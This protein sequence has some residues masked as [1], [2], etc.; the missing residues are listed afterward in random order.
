MTYSGTW[1]MP[2]APENRVPGTLSWDGGDHPVLE[3][4]GQVSPLR[5]PAPPDGDRIEEYACILGRSF[6]G[7]DITCYQCVFAGRQIVLGR[8]RAENERYTI[9]GGALVGAHRANES[10]ARFT[11]YDLSITHLESWYPWRGIHDDQ[12]LVSPDGS[13]L[14]YG[15]SY[16]YSA[17]PLTTEFGRATAKVSPTISITGSRRRRQMRERLT[18]TLTYP[19]PVSP[20]DVQSTEAEALRKLITLAT[21]HTNALEQLAL[22]IGDDPRHSQDGKWLSSRSPRADPLWDDSAAPATLHQPD[23]LFSAADL[24]QG[25]RAQMMMSW[26]ELLSTCQLGMNVLIGDIDSPL[27]YADSRLLS[28]AR[29]IE[30]IARRKYP[31]PATA[32]TKYEER[33]ARLQELVI[34]TKLQGWVRGKLRRAYEP[35]LE[36]RLRRMMADV[37]PA[38]NHLVPSKRF[39]AD[40]AQRRNDYTHEDPASASRVD[41]VQTYW[42]LIQAHYLLVAWVLVAIGFSAPEAQRLLEANDTYSQLAHQLPAGSRSDQPTRRAEPAS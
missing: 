7:E 38:V 26:L 31:I 23:M 15:L 25:H 24:P 2:S 6:D 27:G 28:I 8:G 20:K 5:E 3:L 21:H 13:L 11:T 30:A 40:F 10:D 19:E 41:H 39:A 29:A 1:W 34:D 16:T 36:E 4:N 9:W 37:A 42:L 33:M 14:R 12:P 17:D 35:S 18:M 22:T 32:M